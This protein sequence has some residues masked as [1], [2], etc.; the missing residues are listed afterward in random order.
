MLLNQNGGDYNIWYH[1]TNT[2]FKNI[3]I[4]G[5][6]TVIWVYEMALFLSGQ[7]GNKS[8]E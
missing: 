1:V 5:N 3:L 8:R 2:V 7:L 4:I 6:D